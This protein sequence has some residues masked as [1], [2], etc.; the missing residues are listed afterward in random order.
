[1]K[2]CL[3]TVRI[4]T[5][6]QLKLVSTGGNNYMRRHKTRHHCHIENNANTVYYIC[7]QKRKPLDRLITV[8]WAK[9][10]YYKFQTSFSKAD[11]CD[12]WNTVRKILSMCTH[13]LEDTHRVTTKP[14]MYALFSRNFQTSKSFTVNSC[15]VV[16]KHTWCAHKNLLFW[17]VGWWYMAIK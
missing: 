7:R 1:M 11:L 14:S 8:Y 4:E 2:C 6:Y 10:L 12:S 17:S 5:F 9:S 15:N 16:S 13:I 3:L